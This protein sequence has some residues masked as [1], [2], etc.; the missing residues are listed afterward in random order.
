MDTYNVIGSHR[1]RIGVDMNIENNDKM[2]DVNSGRAVLPGTDA[3]EAIPAS[4][5]SNASASVPL[6]TFSGTAQSFR[7]GASSLCRLGVH[8]VLSGS[9]HLLLGSPDPLPLQTMLHPYPYTYHPHDLPCCSQ[10]RVLQQ[11]SACPLPYRLHADIPACIANCSRCCYCSNTPDGCVGVGVGV[12]MARDIGV[13]HT[14]CFALRNRFRGHAGIQVEDLSPR[15]CFPVVTLGEGRHEVVQ[16]TATGVVQATATGVAA[17]DCEGTSAPTAAAAAVLTEKASSIGVCL[18]REESCP[19]EAVANAAQQGAGAGV[20]LRGPLGSR[21]D[22]IASIHVGAATAVKGESGGEEGAAEPANPAHGAVAAATTAATSNPVAAPITADVTEMA[23]IAAS[24]AGGDP[25]RGDGAEPPP[26][27]PTRLLPSGF[28]LEVL[29]PTALESSYSGAHTAPGDSSSTCSGSCMGSNSGGHYPS[30]TVEYAAMKFHNVAAGLDT[31]AAG[32]ATAAVAGIAATGTWRQSRSAAVGG[33]NAG[34]G[35]GPDVPMKRQA[36]AVGVF[37]AA[38]DPA[39]AFGYCFGGVGGCRPPHRVCIRGYLISGTEAADIDGCGQGRGGGGGA[40]IC[41]HS[42]GRTWRDARQGCGFGNRYRVLGRDLPAGMYTSETGYEKPYCA[43]GGN[44]S[45][46][47]MWHDDFG[48]DDD[49]GDGIPL[50]ASASGEAQF[51][52]EYNNY[53]DSGGYGNSSFSLMP[54]RA[55]VPSYPSGAP[56]RILTLSISG[57]ARDT[58]V[59]STG[60]TSTEKSDWDLILDTG[61]NMA[62]QLSSLVGSRHQRQQQQRRAR[63]RPSLTGSDGSLLGMPVGWEAAVAALGSAVTPSYGS[64]RPRAAANE[65]LDP[66]GR[67][68]CAADPRVSVTAGSGGGDARTAWVRLRVGFRGLARGLAVCFPSLARP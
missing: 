13:S 61:G 42:P 60:R 51:A 27:P 25:S 65:S 53:R 62:M 18:P 50:D 39:S 49:I 36:M 8:S 23:E 40:A 64:S 68:G 57:A 38:A 6:S 46:F 35:A 15:M 1:Y 41:S 26:E 58:A 45:S 66:R 19:A 10:P 22:A 43:R 4:C 56:C 24:S 37:A 32:A 52:L 55:A 29:S 21:A 9:Q 67:V 5:S 48:D 7:F 63:R 11:L 12:S 20:V 17:S 33:M 59:R 34:G 31:A 28:K 16:A 2:D 3:C 14:G 47:G 30:G 54:S 44:A